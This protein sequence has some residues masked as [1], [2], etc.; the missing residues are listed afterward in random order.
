MTGDR[1]IQGVMEQMSYG[2]YIVGSRKG[3]DADGM[4]ADWVMQVSFEP[5]LVA[6]AFESDARTLENIQ[7]TRVFSINLLS[8]DDASMA[9]AAKFAQPYYDA[10]VG[11][12]TAIAARIHHKLDQIPYQLSAG[13][14][15]VLDGAM[16]WIECE[17]EQFVPAG[18]H[19]L[20][21]A[22]VRDAGRLREGEPLTSS[23]TGWNYSG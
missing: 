4:M 6:L 13:G 8:Q 11:G 1:N 19:T 3:D 15:P 10:K 7:A 12:R 2:L 20:V 18:D 16:A 9:L 23:Y 17:P 5:R 21:I 14:C 22:R